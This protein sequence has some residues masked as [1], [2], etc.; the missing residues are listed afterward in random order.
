MELPAAGK[1]PSLPFPAPPAL[2]AV[3]LDVE[4]PLTLPALWCALFH[5]SSG[6]LADFHQH[7]GDLDIEVSP[8]RLKGAWA[9]LLCSPSVCS[10]C[11]VACRYAALRHHSHVGALAASLLPPR[12]ADD[13]RRRVLRYTTPLRNPLGPRQARNTGARAQMLP[14]WRRWAVQLGRAAV[15]AC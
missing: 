4:V 12:S 9:A 1:G 7:L 3:L 2:K 14:L 10:G 6:R 8:W 15:G 13:K 11:A 5:A